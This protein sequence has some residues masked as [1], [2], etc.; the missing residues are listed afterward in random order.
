[1]FKRLVFIELRGL[2]LK[3]KKITGYP[4]FLRNCCGGFK[5][6]GTFGAP[7]PNNFWPNWGWTKMGP[8]PQNPREILHKIDGLW[9]SRPQLFPKLCT[10]TFQMFRCVDLGPRI[11]MLLEADFSKRCFQDVHAE[12]VPLAFVSVLLYLT[13]DDWTTADGGALRILPHPFVASGEAAAAVDVEPRA[14]TLVLFD[15]ATVPHQVLATRRERML[16]AGWLHEPL[17]AAPPA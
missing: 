6:S 14:G 13:P 17:E 12:Y 16:V 5:A 10:R 9:G 8:T 2:Q 11:G 4:W 7:C 15:S 1:M 3:T